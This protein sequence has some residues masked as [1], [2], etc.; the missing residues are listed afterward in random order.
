M[1]TTSQTALEE[2][3]IRHYSILKGQPVP[4]FSIRFYPYCNLNHTIRIRQGRIIVRIS[5]IL[6]QAPLEIISAVLAIL[7]HKLFGKRTPEDDRR[8]YR[9]YIFGRDIQAKAHL[10]R[11]QRGRKVLTQSSGRIY[12]LRTVFD[13]LNQHYFENQ[14]RVRFLSWSRRKNRRILGHYDSAHQTIVIDRRLDAVLVPEYVVEYVL[15]HEML[16]AFLGDEVCSGRRQVH[17]RRFREAEK[18]FEHYRLAKEFIS[19]HLSH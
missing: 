7:L 12:D 9:N 16:H 5:D 3:F 14:V 15:Y 13:R 18:K 1:T 11:S 2:S 19:R 4:S 6:R 17:H 10:M 8:R